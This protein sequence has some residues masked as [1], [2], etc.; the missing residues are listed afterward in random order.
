MQPPEQVTVTHDTALQRFL[1]ETGDDHVPQLLYELTGDAMHMLSVR[2]PVKYRKRGYASIITKT[3]IEY[4]KAEGLRVVPSCPFVLWY[5]NQ[6]PEYKSLLP[7][8]TL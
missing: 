2:V 7:Q 8:A 4:A 6:H 5:L 3:A 1:I